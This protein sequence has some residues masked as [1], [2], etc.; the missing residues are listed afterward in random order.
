ML[1]LNPYRYPI[2]MSSQPLEDAQTNAQDPDDSSRPATA[3]ARQ[4]KQW[5]PPALLLLA[6]L[7]E[8]LLAVAFF[9]A[10]VAGWA[11]LGFYAFTTV[12]LAG[13]N[14]RTFRSNWSL[15]LVGGLGF[16]LVAQLYFKQGTGI[17]IPLLVLLAWAFTKMGAILSRSRR[18]DV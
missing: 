7:I 1:T 14:G 17:Y 6:L 8:P 18:R 10:S 9:P 12:V 4:G 16:W 13:V 2:K 15:P 5:L 11:V 3:P